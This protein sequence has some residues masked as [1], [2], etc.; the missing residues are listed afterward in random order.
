MEE[1]KNKPPAFQFYVKDWL[2]DMNVRLMPLEVK[3]AYIE[4]LSVCWNE[5]YLPKNDK[6]IAKILQ[7]SE[8]KYQK[9]FK[10][11]LEKHFFEDE[12]NS[13]FL[14]NKRLK[15]ERDKQIKN[16][17]KRSEA[18]KIGASKKW[19]KDRKEE[20]KK[21][22]SNNKNMANAINENMAN[23]MAKN[24]SSSS[25]A[26]SSSFKE[27]SNKK[28]DHNVDLNENSENQ[29]I[30][31]EKLKNGEIL[32]QEFLLIFPQKKLEQDAKDLIKDLKTANNPN[33]KYLNPKRFEVN[34]WIEF[35]LKNGD[36]FL[37]SEIQQAIK[38]GLKNDFW[39]NK[40]DTVRLTNP[41]NLIQLL[42]LVDNGNNNNRSKEES[43]TFEP[44]TRELIQA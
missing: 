44:I 22:N 21:E 39:K 33:C 31:I 17:M 7:I 23:A 4:L 14:I 2:S 42:S 34:K 12:K 19:S 32:I 28:E 10:I 36:E 24:S 15:S 18:G 35:F 30:W 9:K 38:N 6:K 29:K 43:K 11:F 5:G 27:K 40:M 3:G 8:K 37:K 16:S 26:S 20:R 1:N 13:E 41:S 25:F